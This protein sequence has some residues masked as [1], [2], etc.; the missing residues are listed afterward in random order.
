MGRDVPGVAAAGT[1]LQRADWLRSRD[2]GCI[3]KKPHW[4][5]SA[6]SWRAP[7]V[8]AS[9]M[10]MA[11][12]S[13]LLCPSRSVDRPLLLSLDSALVFIHIHSTARRSD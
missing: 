13:C 4:P 1:L 2:E 12:R 5:I 3:V 7:A 10:P 9:P 8:Q 6:V 11:G